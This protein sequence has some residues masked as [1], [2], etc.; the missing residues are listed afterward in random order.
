[1][2]K[3]ILTAIC[4]FMFSCDDSNDKEDKMNKPIIIAHRGAQS[5]YPEHT[6]E[7]FERAVKDGAD[8]IEPDLV[9]TKDGH[10]VVR[11]E[12]IL[13]GTTNVSEIEEFASMKTT[14][15]LDGKQITDWFVNDFT[16]KQLKK[17]KARQTWKNRTHEYDDLFHIPT[18]EEVIQ[19]A[20]KG[21][22]ET[23]KVIGIYPEIKHPY[24]FNQY[25]LDITTKVLEVLKK[26]NLDTKE[27][28]VYIQC[29]EVSTLQEIN[30]KSTVKLIQL[31]SCQDVADDGSLLFEVP[32]NEFI[33]N[34]APYDWYKKG[35]KRT[36]EYFT[37]EKGMSFVATYAEGIGPWKPF[38]ISY[39]G[40]DKELL[41]P[42]NFVK[43]AHDNGVK[44][45]PYTFRN[46]DEKW[47]K[48][49][50]EK[51]YHLFFDAGVDGVFS[52]YTAEAVKA[53]RSWKRK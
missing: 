5:V 37:T 35:D 44:V 30:K 38:I 49:T 26:Y 13:S 32:K 51:E 46:E 12:P 41:S 22:K 19:V 53:L 48:G 39:K 7:G 16:L 6:I 25:D 4:V 43:I 52:D 8:F 34:V 20:L 14:R 17:L 15:N 18:F 2:K 45:H 36:Y 1:M 10:L 47:S 31:I 9:M 40:A 29:F 27:S 28:P 33:S 11:H 21:T 50:P 24:Y 42:T 23:G 3:I